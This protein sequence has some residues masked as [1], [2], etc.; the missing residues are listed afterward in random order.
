M[1]LFIAP[2]WIPPP[3]G[4]LK[5]NFDGSALSHPDMAGLGSLVH[6]SNGNILFS[7]SGSAGYYSVNRAESLALLTGLREA[8]RL[9]LRVFKGGK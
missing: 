5:L 2:R 1:N 9:H 8:S 4:V 7:Y 3:L 6:N